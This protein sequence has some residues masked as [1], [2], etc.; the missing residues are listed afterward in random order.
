MGNGQDAKFLV[1]FRMLADLGRH[2]V[3]SMPPGHGN[4]MLAAPSKVS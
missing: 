4:G 3:E 1:Q 2:G